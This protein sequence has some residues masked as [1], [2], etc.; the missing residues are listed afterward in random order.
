MMKK[1]LKIFL[2]ILVFVVFILL[3]L[4]EPIDR[5]P[6]NETMHYH[7]WKTFIKQKEFVEHDGAVEVGWTKV[8]ITPATST[9][10]AGYGNRWGKHFEAVRDSL[11]VRVIAVKNPKT[12]VYLLSA[13]ML[14]IPPNITD[15]LEALLEDE[16]ISISNVHLSATHTHH[17]QGG[18]GLKLAGR[19]FAGAYDLQTEIRLATQFRDA[20]VGA[21]KKMASAQISYDR[22]K[23]EDN[24]RNRLPV[25]GGTVDPWMRNLTFLREDSAQA[26][27]ITYAAHPTVLNRKTLQLSRDYP[28]M[29]LDSIEQ[30]KGKFGVFMAGAVGSMGALSE[31]DS[32]IAWASGVAHGLYS[33]LVAHNIDEPKILANRIVSDYI[34]IPMPAQTARISLRF[35]LRPWVFR[36]F[37]GAYPT[38]VKITKIGDVLLLGMPAD[39]SGEI[40]TELDQYAQQRGLQ[41]V[42]TSFNGGYV[43]YITADKWYDTDLYET[44][45]MSWNG[46]HAGGYFTEVAKDIIDKFGH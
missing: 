33:R 26:K 14:I 17:G 1:A 25:E 12:T 37:F 29:L 46:Y 27:L 23:D 10:M 38:Y 41:L 44:I 22:I 7:A 45:T 43:G 39:F 32:D 42:I 24:I 20:I 31:G 15:R 8:N 3:V 16:G 11:F 34:K 6:I 18:W 40:M 4:V 13:D 35:A 9:P 36:T 28:G 5:T 19:L 2:T 30:Q 21:T